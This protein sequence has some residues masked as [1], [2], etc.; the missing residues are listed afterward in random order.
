MENRGTKIFGL[1]LIVVGILLA[2]DN[3]N[4]DLFEYA[5]PIAIILFGFYLIYRSS[6]GQSL[7]FDCST[8]S[9]FIGDSTCDDYTGDVDGINFS[10]FIGDME[11]NL[12]NATFKQ[13]ENKIII[14]SFIG[15][16][17]VAVPSEVAVRVHCSSAFGDFQVFDRKDEGIF[18][19]FKY[20]TSDYDSAD[21]KI[22]FHCS[23]F[24]GDMKISKIATA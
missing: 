11:L 14:S 9:K 12:K 16:I 22:V 24:I 5:W 4:I 20:S 23:S 7:S 18:N 19:S 10:H 1:V 6:R 2:L 17:K 13:G 8:G 21:K 15:D 3:F